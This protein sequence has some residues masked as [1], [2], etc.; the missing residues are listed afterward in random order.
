MYG[1]TVVLSGCCR[2]T[3][4]V[5]EVKTIKGGHCNWE[6]VTH[7]ISTEAVQSLLSETMA[8]KLFLL[9]LYTSD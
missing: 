8:V 2:W 7:K 4:K 3:S 6:A 1:V 5:N 9:L